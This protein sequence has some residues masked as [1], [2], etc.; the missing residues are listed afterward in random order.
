MFMRTAIDDFNVEIGE[1]R[2]VKKKDFYE[3]MFSV[4]EGGSVDNT[5]LVHNG[6]IY[7]GSLNRNVYAL[8]IRT[9]E[10]VWKF[11]TR[12]SVAISS[13]SLYKNSIIISSYDH[14]VYR[15]DLSTGCMIWKFRTNK[16]IMSTG[17][18]EGGVYY[19]TGIDQFLYAINCED[20]SLVWKYKASR[21]NISTPTVHETK[22]FFGSSD[23]NLY[24]I[25]RLRG[26]LVWKLETEEE[27]LNDRPFTIIDDILYFGTMGSVLRAVDVRTGK[28]LWKLETGEYGIVCGSVAL[29]DLLIQPTLGGNIFAIKAKERKVAWKISNNYPYA[30]PVTDGE[31][32]YLGSED[33]NLYCLNK[34][35]KVLWKFKTEAPIWGCPVIREGVL[36][37]GSYDCNMYALEAITGELVWKFRCSGSISTYTPLKSFF[38]LDVKV[39]KE[40]F[41]EQR[42]KRYELNLAS[43]EDGDSNFYKSRIT[44]Q[45]STQYSSKGKYQIDS[46]EESF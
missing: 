6:L 25:D 13:P 37:F 38:E 11:R 26:T 20:G 21:P 3:I 4:T 39:P 36:Y 40:E 8:D 9:G 45:V 41:K 19:F 10:E 33:H 43:S 27:I 16:E 35:G 34:F 46:Q 5:P 17:I 32:I 18:I 28:G 29:N 7:F 12:G 30:S 24:C 22:V 15:I 23:R 44:Y 1:F 42:E 31:R 2:V 14:N